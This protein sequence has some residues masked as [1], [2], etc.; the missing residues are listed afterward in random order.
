M[1]DV[2]CV[3]GQE[4]IISA[5]RQLLEVRVCLQALSAPDRIDSTVGLDM[6]RADVKRE[7][8]VGERV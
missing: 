6:R 1:S 4:L 3:S 7:I 2:A 8:P 5:G